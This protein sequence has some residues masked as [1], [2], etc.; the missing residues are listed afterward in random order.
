V[1]EHKRKPENKQKPHD[2]RLF[3]K[4]QFIFSKDIFTLSLKFNVNFIFG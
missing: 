2:Y 4:S 3:Q 1:F